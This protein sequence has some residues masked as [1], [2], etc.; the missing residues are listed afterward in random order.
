[1]KRILVDGDIVYQPEERPRPK[2]VLETPL[3]FTAFMLQGEK[4]FAGNFALF[5]LD[6]N[7]FFP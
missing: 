1:M 4:C 7:I 6:V 2:K 5:L 3:N